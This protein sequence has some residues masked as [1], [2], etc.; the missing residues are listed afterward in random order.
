MASRA[1]EGRV[2]PLGPEPEP[3]SSTSL[4]THHASNAAEVKAATLTGSAFCQYWIIK[5]VPAIAG[6]VFIHR[7]NGGQ[8]VVGRT[9]TE[10]GP[11][12]TSA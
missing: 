4:K 3:N 2:P 12:P 7:C 8:E 10:M 6:T 9:Y 5:T 1:T 11:F